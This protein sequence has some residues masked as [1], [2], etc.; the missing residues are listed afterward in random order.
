MLQGATPLQTHL[1]QGQAGGAMAHSPESGCLPHGMAPARGQ[2][3][4]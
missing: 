4:A 2:D 3:I 1:N